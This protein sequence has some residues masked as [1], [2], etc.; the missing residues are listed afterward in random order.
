M[1]LSMEMPWRLK[2]GTVRKDHGHERHQSQLANPNPRH[3]Q[4][5]ARD[6]V[7]K[8]K[9]IIRKSTMHPSTPVFPI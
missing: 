3:P 2:V 1:C 8:M 5:R 7:A 9:V 4:M 6:D